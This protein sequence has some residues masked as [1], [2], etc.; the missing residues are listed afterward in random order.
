[1][2]QGELVISAAS[3]VFIPAEMFSMIGMAVAF[4]FPAASRGCPLVIPFVIVIIAI[5]VI[6]AI[7]RIAR[8]RYILRRGWHIDRTRCILRRVWH[9][10]PR[11]PIR[12]RLIDRNGGLAG[13]AWLVTGPVCWGWPVG[14]PLRNI[15]R[16]RSVGSSRNRCYRYARMRSCAR[17]WILRACVLAKAQENEGECQKCRNSY[18]KMYKLS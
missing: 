17:C 3:A 12:R 15:R 14:R 1:M 10:N 8:S 16:Y 11:W 18:H 6:V 5:R 13:V 4:L 7:R 2:K 9:I